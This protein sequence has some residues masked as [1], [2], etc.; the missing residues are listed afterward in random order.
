VHLAIEVRQVVLARPVADLVLAAVGSSVAVRSV[1][2]VVLQ[3]L[4]VLAFE[5]L[6]EDD[7]AD[8]EIRMLLSEAA[9][10][11]AERRVETRIVID[12]TGATNASVKCLLGL[13]V[14]LQ[15]VR[16]E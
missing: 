10:L 14:P 13:A 15:G 12:L 2:V 1:A 4:L 3:E 5:I 6:L 7:A 16:V 8:L 11:L 9:F